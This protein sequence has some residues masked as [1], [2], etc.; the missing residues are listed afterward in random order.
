MAALAY[1][2]LPVTGL[3]AF[4]SGRDARTRF[5]GLQAICIG[6]AWPVVL[7][8]AALGPAAAVQAVFAVGGLVWLSFLV[9]TAFG[10]DPGL[11]GLGRALRS[12]SATGTKDAPRSTSGN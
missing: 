4:L 12:L 7:Y 9:A 10:R 3:I 8:L 6:L 2:L 1:L 11:P 5:H